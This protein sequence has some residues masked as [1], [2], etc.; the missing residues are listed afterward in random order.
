VGEVREIVGDARTHGEQSTKHSFVAPQ[1]VAAAPPLPSEPRPSNRRWW[2]LA[3]AMTTLALALVLWTHAHRGVTTA[4]PDRRSIALLPFKNLGDE[5]ADVYFADGLAEDIVTH[6]ARVPGLRV[7]S[8]A[9]TQAYRDST[10]PLR[11]IGSDLGAGTV[12]EGSIRRTGDRTRITVKLTDTTTGSHLWAETYD[13]DLQDVLGVQSDVASKVAGV[14]ALRIDRK[15]ETLLRGGTRH[16]EAY[17]LYLRALSELDRWMVDDSMDAAIGHLEKA[18]ALDPTFARAHAQ[19][20]WA[21]ARAGLQPN[22]GDDWFDKTRSAADRALAL[23][24]GLALPHVARSFLLWGDRGGWDAEG[25]IRELR[26]A[27]ELEPGTGHLELGVL[28]AHLGLDEAAR[29]EFDVALSYNPRS[30]WIRDRITR[31][32][33]WLARDAEAVAKAHEWFSE[34]EATL[35]PWES[36]VRLGHASEVLRAA[37]PAKDKWWRPK[38]ALAL[39]A[40]GASPSEARGHIRNALDAL[41]SKHTNWHHLA[42][43]AA[44]IE[45]LLGDQDAAVRWLREVAS[46]GFPNYLLF[47]TDPYLDS[48]RA[49]PGFVQLMAELKPKWELRRTAYR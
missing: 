30:H 48:V 40:T 29:R 26:R 16:P 25:G 49:H 37:D 27:Q 43:D 13:R 42:Y 14:L 46:N 21:H 31:S 32:Y 23:E 19:L 36:A 15:D 11:T 2:T 39:A 28:F 34:Q 35:I 22:T 8:R 5:H 17:D 1:A 18:V 24:P 41:G 45:A 6:L 38:R 20:A 44:C 33:F 9:S 12:I 47:S 7:I 3:T 10:T 4:P